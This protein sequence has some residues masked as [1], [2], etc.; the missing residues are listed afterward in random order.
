MGTWKNPTNFLEGVN[1]AQK[2][3]LYDGQSKSSESTHSM[4]CMT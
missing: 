4:H 1:S 3:Y 2:F